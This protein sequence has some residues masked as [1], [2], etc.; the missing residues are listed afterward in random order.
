MFGFMNRLR[1][2]KKVPT[3]QRIIEEDQYKERSSFDNEKINQ[4][5]REINRLSNNIPRFNLIK[6]IANAELE[7]AQ[8][9]YNEGI[10][11]NALRPEMLMLSKKLEDAKEKLK[12]NI[13]NIEENNK[14]LEKNKRELDMLDGNGYRGGNKRRRRRK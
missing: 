3:L 1:S 4:L 12:L 7:E 2:S 9:D 8:Q 11:N 10:D 14:E 13:K 6:Q 5:R